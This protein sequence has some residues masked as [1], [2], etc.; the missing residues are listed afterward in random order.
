MGARPRVR[1]RSILMARNA[2]TMRVALLPI[3][4]S[5]K[6]SIDLLCLQDSYQF[7]QTN[8]LS[9]YTCRGNA[10]LSMNITSTG[11]CLSIPS[12]P[13]C[14]NS[15]YTMLPPRMVAWTPFSAIFSQHYSVAQFAGGQGAFALLL[16]PGVGSSHCVAP[17]SILDGERLIRK[18]GW[19]LQSGITTQCGG[20]KDANGI[21]DFYRSIGTERQGDAQIAHRAI[22]VGATMTFAPVPFCDIAVGYSMEGL[23]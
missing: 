1:Q 18:P 19:T 11:V 9:N 10:R 12:S 20:I 8:R 5:Y 15:P 23:D 7:T 16:S 6:T 3:A 4:L 2:I 14:Y 17:E 13:K 22:G 21:E